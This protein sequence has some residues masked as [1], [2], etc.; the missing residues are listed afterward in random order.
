LKIKS[1]ETIPVSIPVKPEALSFGTIDRVDYVITRLET[2]QFTGYGEAATLQ[3]PT[4]SE[5]SRETIEST[6]N[7]YLSQAVVGNNTLDC[8]RIMTLLDDRVKGNSFAK[9]A[10][11]MAI[12]DAACKELNIPVYQLLGGKYRDSIPLSWTLANNDAA[13]DAAE[14]KDRVQKGW[15]ILKIK[16]GS[17]PL[18]KDLERVS[19][20]RAAV[21][22]TISVRVDANQGW[23]VNQTVAA[24]R[25]LEDTHID[26]LEQ[27]VP[28]WDLEG[29][30][31]IS[32]R[33]SMPIMADE[34]VCTVQD[35]VCLLQKRA[36]S[37]F[38]YKLTKM[39]GLLNAKTIERLADSYRIG[40]YVGCMIETS[41]GTAAYLQFGASV[42]RLSYGCELFG[43]LRIK[44]DIAKKEIQFENGTIIVPDQPGIGVEVDESK[45]DQLSNARA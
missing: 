24:L 27:P 30:N 41:V 36:V 22:D 26:F 14:A 20:V 37:A 32:R 5:E 28:K 16:T 19:A 25:T 34:A 12:L 18:K 38:S 44:S 3:G 43:P 29:L 45:L 40:G 23:N 4:W 9:A 31:E 7:K 33:T 10:V 11:E 39:G 8:M 6:I 42:H 13:L 1:L 35:A 21:G 2:S 15:K 17:L